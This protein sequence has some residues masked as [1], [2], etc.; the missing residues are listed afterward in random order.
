MHGRLQ[1]LNE[2]DFELRAHALGNIIK[3]GLIAR[4]LEQLQTLLGCLQ[5]HAVL[6]RFVAEN[7]CRLCVRAELGTDRRTDMVGSVL[8]LETRI[9]CETASVE[10]PPL[11]PIVNSFFVLA[12]GVLFFFLPKRVFVSNEIMLF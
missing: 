2:S 10:S 3:L 5:Q 8:A 1:H 4:K 11:V 12:I 6:F 7:R 9:R